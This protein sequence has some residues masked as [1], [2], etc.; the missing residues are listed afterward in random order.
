M[1]KEEVYYG[2][3]MNRKLVDRGI[4]IFIPQYVIKGTVE[5]EQYDEYVASYFIDSI[6]N[7]EYLII[8][9]SETLSG[10][11]E[12]AVGYVISQKD[13]KKKYPGVPINTAISEYFD[14]INSR[15]TFGFYLIEKDQIAIVPLDLNTLSETLNSVKIEDSANLNVELQAMNADSVPN[16]K[17]IDIEVLNR[18]GALN[19]M[20]EVKEFITDIFDKLGVEVMPTNIEDLKKTIKDTIKQYTEIIKE[21]KDTDPEFAALAKKIVKK[22][23]K[24][25]TCETIEEITSITTDIRENEVASLDEMVADE[26][27]KADK[28]KSVNVAEMKE[29]FDAK[30]IGQEE[31]K[32]DVISAIKMNSLTE[33]PSDKNN[34]LLI[35]PT[36]SGKTLLAEATSEFLDMPMVIVDTTQLSIAGYKGSQIED[37]LLK[38]IMSTNGDVEKAQKG[39]VVFDEIDKKATSGRSDTIGAGALNSLLPFIQGTVY[40]VEITPHNTIQFDTSNLTIFA[41]GAFTSVATNTVVPNKIGFNSE[42]EIKEVEEDIKYS[43]LTIEDLVSKGNMP[44]ELMGRFSTITQLSGHTIESL[45]TILTK[46]NRSTLLAEAE[47]LKKLGIELR[48]TE[49][50]LNKVAEEAL[51]LKTGARSLKMIVEKSVKNVRWEVLTN[52]D[53]YRAII[54]TEKTV[55]DNND[56][57]LIDVNGNSMNFSQLNNEEKRMKKVIK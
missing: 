35:G 12:V 57:E 52:E 23:R 54:L 20:D 56:C 46:S 39:I 36:G 49:G 4:Y 45:K 33:S 40:D 38:L 15:V 14:E 30:I 48:W 1:E 53:L 6:M 19:S 51:K 9:D 10:D 24:A 8:N 42:T 27:E 13:L 43:K 11:E 17:Y 16:G 31:A 47:K 21:N 50:Y 7:M 18:I 25:L 29:F 41:T 55:L 5:Q 37:F 26:Y 32:I 22:L 28:P 3:L 44:V 2:I 34:V